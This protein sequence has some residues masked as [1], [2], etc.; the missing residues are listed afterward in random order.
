MVFY[1]QPSGKFANFDFT[2]CGV[3]KGCLGFPAGCG[4]YDDCEVVVSWQQDPINS[5]Q[6]A[7]EIVSDKPEG[8]VSLGWSRDGLMVA[9]NPH[10]ILLPDY[11]KL[12][13]N[14]ACTDR[15]P[16]G[17]FHQRKHLA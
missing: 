6:V 13:V 15:L 8:Y 3:D 9:N 2:K 7:M 4:F 16:M 5:D 14:Q 17:L 10:H 11:L 1:F 12:T